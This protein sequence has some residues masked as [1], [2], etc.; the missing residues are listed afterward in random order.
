MT[1]VAVSGAG[2]RMGRLVAE[3]VAA[4]DGMDLVAAYDPS[5]AGDA[6]GGVVIT[7]ASAAVADAQVVVEFTVPDVVMGN[8]QQWRSLGVHAVVGTS[9]FDAE[10]IAALTEVWGSGPPNCLVV[11]NFSI[12][13]VLMMRFAQEAAPHFDEVR[14]AERHHTGKVDAPSGTALATG[15]RIVGAGGPVPKITSERL[16]EVVAHHEVTFTSPS[17]TLSISHDTVDRSSFIPGVLLA[18][19][20][21]DTLPDAVTVGLEAVL[22]S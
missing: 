5:H 17:E 8:L 3:A 1:T 9:G 11:P 22:S 20:R 21:V 16:D 18:I 2:G 10:R 7:D 4:T 14:I 6:V 12:G 19:E 13:A 15:D